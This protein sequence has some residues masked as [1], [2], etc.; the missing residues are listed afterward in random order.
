MMAV[1]TTL[2]QR[3]RSLIV[4]AAASSDGVG[5]IA[6]TLKWGQPSF[7]PKKPRIGSSVRLQNN[8]DGSMSLMFI[9]NTNLVERFREIYADDLNFI[10]NREIKVQDADNIPENALKHCIAMALTY[11][12]AK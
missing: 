1:A 7:A 11:H 10:G 2:A 4:E 6:E 9:C 3:L 12:L 8:D 5:E